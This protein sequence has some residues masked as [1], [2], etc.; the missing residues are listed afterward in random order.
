MNLLVLACSSDLTNSLVACPV[1]VI[2]V[3]TSSSLFYC[4]YYGVSPLELEPS[5]SFFPRD[6]R[7]ARGGES[8]SSSPLKADSAS[9]PRLRQYQYAIGSQGRVLPRSHDRHVLSHGIVQY[10]RGGDDDT[11]V[12]QYVQ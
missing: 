2:V 3:I 12:I 5:S 10:M 6:F 1:A 11:V 8:G 9:T 4:P 7:W